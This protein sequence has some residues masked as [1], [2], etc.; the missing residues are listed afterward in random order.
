MKENNGGGF[1]LI[2]LLVVVAVLSVLIAVIIPRFVNAR[3]TAHN[4]AAEAY[5]HNL[6]VWLASAEAESKNVTSGQFRGNCLSAELRE[7]GAP[8]VLP[9]S[10]ALCAVAYANNH[11]TVTVTSV[12]GKGG[13][14]SN[15]VFTAAY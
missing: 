2:E 3:S 12:T 9:T 8:D 15:G 14:T 5:A 10:V 4:G 11:Y 7:Q 13:P 6:A 1:T